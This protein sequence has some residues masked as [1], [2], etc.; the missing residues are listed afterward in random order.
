[1]K[2]IK[3]DMTVEIIQKRHDD[4][5]DFLSISSSLLELMTKNIA[6]GMEIHSHT[7]CVITC[8]EKSNVG[9]GHEGK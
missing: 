9:G 6:V 3:V 7:T 5:I 4:D 1:M 2:K 8:D